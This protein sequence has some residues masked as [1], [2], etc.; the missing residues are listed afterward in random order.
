MADKVFVISN[1]E[2]EKRNIQPH[3]LYS[4]S[5][6][7]LEELATEVYTAKEAVEKFNNNEIDTNENFVVYREIG[8]EEIH[9]QMG[10][11]DWQEIVINKD[12]QVHIS[13]GDE[14]YSVDLYAWNEDTA[15]D[16]RDYDN[17]FIS[18]C[19]ASYEEL[20]EARKGTEDEN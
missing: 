9:V 6:P 4:T 7:L 14:G 2:L 18:S 19:W 10:K 5:I 20:N 13:S 15:D 11:N 17:E 16:E 1:A 12:L 3:T 8:D